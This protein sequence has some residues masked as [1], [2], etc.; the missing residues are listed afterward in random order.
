MM[1]EQERCGSACKNP[2][3]FKGQQWVTGGSWKHLLFVFDKQSFE[4]VA[5]LE[6][7]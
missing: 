5:S 4:K 1:E 3:R 6:L 7:R 2:G